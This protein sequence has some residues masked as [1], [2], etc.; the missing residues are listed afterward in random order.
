MLIFSTTLY[1][2][3]NRCA[4]VYTTFYFFHSAKSR[5]SSRTVQQS[6]GYIEAPGNGSVRPCFRSR[7]LQYFFFVLS[8]SL[9][10]NFSAPFL[11]R[12]AHHGVLSLI[13]NPSVTGVRYKGLPLSFLPL[14]EPHHWIF[15]PLLLRYALHEGDYDQRLA[16][17]FI[18]R[19]L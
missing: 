18:P 11:P 19:L 6:R 10:F 3:R 8:P 2:C 5:K 15:L 1:C 17:I 14:P 9:S 13:C 7:P 16:I 12:K 4:D